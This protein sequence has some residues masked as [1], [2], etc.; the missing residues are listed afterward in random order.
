MFNATTKTDD[1]PP[2]MNPFNYVNQRKLST[3]ATRLREIDRGNKNLLKSINLI[4]RTIVNSKQVL[5]YF[6]R[7]SLGASAYLQS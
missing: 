3:D 2:K 5:I 6:L 7:Y 4:N 1:L